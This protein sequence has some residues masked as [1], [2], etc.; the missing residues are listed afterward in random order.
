MTKTDTK[1]R[2]RV[3]LAGLLLALAP[4]LA[5]MPAMALVVTHDLGGSVR[6][7]I[8]QVDM[9]TAR[10]AEVRIL[11]TCLSAC[12][13]LLGVPDA[14]V[15]PSARLGFHGPSTRTAGLPLPRADYDR[16]SMQMA[17]LYPQPLRGWFLTEARYITGT[18]VEITGRDAIA[19]GARR[20]D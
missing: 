3:S 20:C 6:D 19:M 18:Y 13:L 17:A 12:T 16:I 7:R 5:P 4:I 15:S 14:C 2:A 9:L 10:K 11:G 8:A 1:H